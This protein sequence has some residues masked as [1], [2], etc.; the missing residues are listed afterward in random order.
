MASDPRES[1]PFEVN[2]DAQ[3]HDFEWDGSWRDIYVFGT[4]TADWENVLDLIRNGS[5][6]QSWSRACRRT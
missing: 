4:S 5:Y 1:P 3:R 6:R 2:W